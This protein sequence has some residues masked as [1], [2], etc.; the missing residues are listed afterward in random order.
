MINYIMRLI[1][2]STTDNNLYFN[3]NIQADI[4][5][6]PKSKICCLNVNF[7]KAANELYIDD[8]TGNVKVQVQDQIYNYDILNN[9]Y[10]LSNYES[11][12]ICMKQLS[13]SK[14]NIGEFATGYN[15]KAIGL[16]WNVDN[17]DALNTVIST[18]QQKPLDPIQDAS[19]DDDYQA[20][21][22]TQIT[23]ETFGY[24]NQDVGSIAEVFT[25]SFNFPT[26]L[27][28]GT[29]NIF[30]GTKR[31]CIYTM[32]IKEIN[33]ASL[34]GIFGFM[35]NPTTQ[36]RS[37]SNNYFLAISF[38]DD[39]N[40][41]ILHYE[42]VD[43][44]LAIGN[45][46]DDDFIMFRFTDNQVQCRIFNAGNPD[47]FD[48]H[49]RTD[50]IADAIYPV[51]QLSAPLVEANR[52]VIENL[53]V[54]PNV[55]PDDVFTG[56]ETPALTSV[57]NIPVPN[58][59]ETTFS[60]ELTEDVGRFLGYKSFLRNET[61]NNFSWVSENAIILYDN[62]EN[63]I[64]ELVNIDLQSYDGLKGVEQRK[65]ILM[66]IVNSR[67]RNQPDVAFVSTFPVWLNI[68][69]AFESFIRNIKARI[70]HSDYRQVK[71]QGQANITLLIKDE[72]D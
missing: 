46:S 31:N 1:R 15:Q 53:S 30:Q 5:L 47:G 2:L 36:N 25:D 35:R 72:D 18:T 56:V 69:N 13:Q 8:S 12:L 45:A 70:V 29:A 49:S 62:S 55:R 42:G 32:S 34:G 14:L 22:F 24:T 59:T 50:V 43:T 37:D 52:V 21:N 64:V 6:S 39:T 67:E 58:L 17:N 28:T 48:A 44:T 71:A 33:S 7:E 54:I 66:N 40:P 51:L 60:Y 9:T 10:D 19:Q 61:N 4:N 68:D 16:L 63:Y 3:N 65:N 26:S 41:Y 11:L 57:Y 23:P 20:F 38:T 27:N